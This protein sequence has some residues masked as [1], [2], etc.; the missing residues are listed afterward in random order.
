MTFVCWGGEGDGSSEV[1]LA[2]MWWRKGGVTA[3][4][5]VNECN[6]LHCHLATTSAHTRPLLQYTSSEMRQG[7]VSMKPAN[8]DH[9]ADLSIDCVCRCQQITGPERWRLPVRHQGRYASDE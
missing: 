2:S 5:R 8:Q 7:R 4:I 3:S 1:S 9:E 6:L